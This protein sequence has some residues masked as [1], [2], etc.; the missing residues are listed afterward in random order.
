MEKFLK[1]RLPSL[2]CDLVQESFD[3]TLHCTRNQT[4][5]EFV[6]VFASYD[7]T[8][9]STDID[10]GIVQQ[11]RRQITVDIDQFD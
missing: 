2:R 6:A 8:I 9:T 4:F 1:Q 3:R 5:V 11:R 10:Y 7:T